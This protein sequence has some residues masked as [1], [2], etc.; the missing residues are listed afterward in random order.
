MRTALHII[1]CLFGSAAAFAVWARCGRFAPRLPSFALKPSDWLLLGAL[2]CA[3]LLGC[4]QAGSLSKK[5]FAHDECKAVF[6][7]AVGYQ[8]V[9]FAAIMLF[10][11]F[12]AAQINFCVKPCLRGLAMGAGWAVPMFFVIALLGVAVAFITLL[13]TGEPP[14][15][16]DIV[17]LLKKCGDAPT[18]VLA[19]CSIIV[20]A[21]ICEELLF[22]GLLY[23]LTKGFFA[24]SA[25]G[26]RLAALVTAAIFALA[27]GNAFAF[28][29]LFATSLVLTSLYE[30][31]G[32]LFASMVCHG[33]F[34]AINACCI[35]FISANEYF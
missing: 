1:I 29:Q 18:L 9:L 31:S 8:A 24:A 25:G 23:R 28:A 7:Y 27:H 30:R 21:P 15:H 34:N 5:M 10:K 26:A 17:S 22:R 14:R 6:F 16:Q 3:V 20:F 35:I 13:L 19:G 2:A 12:A 32:S 11:R 4:I 33:V